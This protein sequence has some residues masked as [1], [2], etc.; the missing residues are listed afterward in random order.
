MITTPTVLI[1]GA[2]AS[3]PYR[4]PLGRP[5]LT[6]ICDELGPTSRPDQRGVIEE[7][8]FSKADIA[9]FR[10]ELRHSDFGSVDEFLEHNPYFLPIGKSAIAASLIPLENHDHLFPPHAPEGHHWYK[11]LLESLDPAGDLS[12]N[13]LS[14]LTFNYDRSLEEYLY[15]AL[16][17]R[18]HCSAEEA[19]DAC[20]QVP[21]I[22]LYGHL[23]PYA[24]F[25]GAG[26]S[27]SPDL[28]AEAV[29]LA[30]DSMKIVHESEDDTPEFSQAAD[31]LDRAQ[32]IQFLGFGYHP[33]NVRRLRVFNSPWDEAQRV[34]QEVRG[35]AQGIPAEEWKVI[36]DDVLH[37][38]L[39]GNVYGG[40]CYNFLRQ[41][42]LT[43]P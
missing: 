9:T 35:T 22:H 14:I 27:Y 17:A 21:I 15:S 11:Q 1:L 12:Q 8:D 32:R 41:Y 37:G 2:G 39:R 20:Q 4:F 5:L 38:N 31:L 13:K 7:L 40:D 28:T 34:R 33:T 3:N 23:G 26:R 30:R 29:R 24:N 42:P 16:R 36:S 6:K 10:D 25:T 19:A 18:R 43:R